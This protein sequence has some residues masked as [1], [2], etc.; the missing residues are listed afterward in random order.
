MWMR[1]LTTNT[2]TADSKIGSHSSCSPVMTISCEVGAVSCVASVRPEA[3][4]P[5]VL[6]LGVPQRSP[7]AEPHRLPSANGV[8]RDQRSDHAQAHRVWRAADHHIHRQAV[9]AK[10]RRKVYRL[11]T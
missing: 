1:E 6:G 11:V 5:E 4:L 9:A 7:V 3:R 2:I 10:R 8:D